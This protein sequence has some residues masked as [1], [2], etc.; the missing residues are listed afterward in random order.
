MERRAIIPLIL[1]TVSGE[2]PATQQL[3]LASVGNTIKTDTGLI[4]T[5]DRKKSG[6]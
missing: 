1:G 2:D 6:D 5:T 3:L 4:G